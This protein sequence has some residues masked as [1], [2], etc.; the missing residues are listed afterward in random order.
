MHVPQC[1]LAAAVSVV[2]VGASVV[3][4]CIGSSGVSRAEAERIL[5]SGCDTHCFTIQ[6]QEQEPT[7]FT[8]KSDNCIQ[9]CW[10]HLNE[11]C[12]PG[13]GDPQEQCD[14]DN[15][16]LAYSESCKLCIPGTS[17][18]CTLGASSTSGPEVSKCAD[19]T[20]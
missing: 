16:W 17:G 5:G 19:C 7:C 15:P 14:G 1:L 20:Q 10:K 2:A 9:L 3:T 13:A 8:L 4:A 6:L 18:R 11:R 12:D